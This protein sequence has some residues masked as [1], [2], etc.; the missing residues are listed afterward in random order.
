MQGRAPRPHTPYLTRDECPPS[1][2]RRLLEPRPRSLTNLAL[3]NSSAFV[4]AFTHAGNAVSLVGLKY[5]KQPSS[6][7]V[8]HASDPRS[9]EGSTDAGA[10]GQDGA[11][12]RDGAQSVAT[13]AGT[14]MDLTRT[15]WLGRLVLL[16]APVCVLVMSACS[17]ARPNC[18]VVSCTSLPFL[19]PSPCFLGPFGRACEISAPRG[20]LREGAPPASLKR[21][22]EALKRSLSAP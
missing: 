21:T 20:S 3:T 6:A 14:V 11:P 18:S 2:T 16:C 19:L 8:G 1:L 7:C 22:V 4:H 10:R 5:S 17:S 15:H 13:A 12:R 9:W